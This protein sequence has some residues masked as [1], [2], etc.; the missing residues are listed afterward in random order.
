MKKKL[1]SEALKWALANGVNG[2][3]TSDGS[4]VYDADDAGCAR[5]IVPPAHL[6]E[7]LDTHIKE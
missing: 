5:E 4:V 1:L 3:H 2:Y 7:V 6:K